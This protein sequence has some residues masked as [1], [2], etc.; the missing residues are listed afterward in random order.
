M[1]MLAHCERMFW[2]AL[3]QVS[4]NQTALYRRVDPETNVILFERIISVIPEQPAP[5][6]FAFEDC[7]LY[8]TGRVYKIGQ[9]ELEGRLP[10]EGD[11]LT[12]KS[13]DTKTIYTVSRSGNGH[14]YE[15]LGNYGIVLRVYVTGPRGE[16]HDSE[17]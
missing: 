2:N 14:C 17:Y 6:A 15:E 16:H 7:I 1:N 5:D 10:Q 13:G 8:K 9:E 3:V 12:F 4:G 11:T